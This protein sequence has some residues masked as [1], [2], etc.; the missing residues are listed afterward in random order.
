MSGENDVTENERL[1]Q[2]NS[3]NINRH[4]IVLQE[5]VSD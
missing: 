1:T 3:S 5:P 4:V 2:K